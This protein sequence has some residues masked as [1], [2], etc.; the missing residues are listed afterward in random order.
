MSKSLQQVNSK[1]WDVPVMGAV[2]IGL[3][4]AGWFTPT[5]KMSKFIFGSDE[6][7]I[8]QSV[9]GL[10]EAGD[11]VLALIIFFFS[12][13]FPTAKLGVLGWVWLRPMPEEEQQSTLKWVEALGK[14]SM[15]DVFV[16][17]VTVVLVKAKALLDAE[18]MYGIYLF[19]AAIALS[20]IVSWRV[21]RLAKKE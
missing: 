12:M 4:I 11:Y 16:V 18:P 1:A 9:A 17:A 20:M 2:A 6:Y 7:S 15:L 14:W 10:W 21:N 5:V 8:W 3:L 19:A 13:I